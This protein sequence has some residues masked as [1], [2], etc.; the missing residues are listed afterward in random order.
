MCLIFVVW[1]FLM[2]GCGRSPMAGGTTDTGNPRVAALI[3]ANDGSRA[4]GASVTLRLKNYLSRVPGAGL[5]KDL[6]RAKETFTDDS[7]YFEID[8]I[9]SGDYFIEVNDRLFSAALLTAT[10]PGPARPLIFLTDTLRPYAGIVG[11]T[12]QPSGPSVKMYLLAYGLERRIPIDSTGHFEIKN[13]PSGTL[14]FRIVSQDTLFNPFDIDNIVLAPGK[15]DTVPFAGWGH[16]TSIFLNTTASGADVMSLVTDFPV[17]VRLTS[18]NFNFSEAKANGYDVRFAKSDNTPLSYEIERWDAVNQQAEIWVKMDRVYGNDIT[19][20]INMYWGNPSAPGVSNAEGVF[21]TASGFQG[22]WH[23]NGA[24]NTTAYD[25]TGNHY[26]GTPHGMTASSSVSGVIGLSRQFDGT[27]SYFTMPNTASST[28]NLPENGYYTVSAWTNTNYLDAKYQ[29]I[30]YKSNWQYGLQ[31]HSDS[32]WEFFEYKDGQG[33][34]STRNPAIAGSWYNITGV[35]Q[36]EHQYLYVNGVCVDSIITFGSMTN[37]RITNI[38]L[39]IGHCQDGGLE[40][41][42]FF[43]GKIDEVRI[44]NIALNADW[45]KLC[46]MNQRADDKLVVFK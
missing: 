31:I 46:Y 10:V 6:V 33:W 2:S 22:V 3:Y 5:Q 36:G 13:L 28:L 42:R 35:R 23:L 1:L 19:H 43:N 25:A 17:L 29:G 20:F 32:T 39:Q 38:D 44:A 26:N 24:G 40:P 41:D 14:L 8:S 11:N 21:D 34:E 4:K 7:G 9:E 27:S 45:I 15:I 16:S 12:S 30:V 18:G 37:P